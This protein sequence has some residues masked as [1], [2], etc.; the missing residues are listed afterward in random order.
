MATYSVYLPKTPYE[1]FSTN[2]DEKAVQFIFIWNE[3]QNSYAV[4]ITDEA[5]VPY[6]EGRRLIPWSP[7][8]LEVIEPSIFRGFINLLPIV[9]N[10]DYSKVG[11]PEQVGLQYGLYYVNDD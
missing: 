5:G 8:Y 10:P 6:V 3:R 2:L 11:M 7:I 9:D 1:I 4:T